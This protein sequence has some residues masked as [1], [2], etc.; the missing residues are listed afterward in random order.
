MGRLLG[1]GL[2]VLIGA[3][4]LSPA[5]AFFGFSPLPGDFHV[6]FGDIHIYL[7][8]ETSLIASG[9]LTLLFFFLRR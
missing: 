6:N 9:A 3:L 2:I 5:V 4:I 7:P 1:W 8:L